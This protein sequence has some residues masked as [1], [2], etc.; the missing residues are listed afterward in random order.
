DHG[1][2][3]QMLESG[4]QMGMNVISAKYNLVTSQTRDSSYK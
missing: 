2:S 4:R 1:E 3:F